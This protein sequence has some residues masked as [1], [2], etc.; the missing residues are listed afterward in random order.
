MVL[1][2]PAVVPLNQ[3]LDQKQIL[4]KTKHISEGEEICANPIPTETQK[5]KT[6]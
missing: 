5:N 4:K 6:C 2:D 3:W 1:F